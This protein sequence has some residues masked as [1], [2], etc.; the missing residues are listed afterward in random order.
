MADRMIPEGGEHLPVS[1]PRNLALGI[2]RIGLLPIRYPIVA[3]L[4]FLVLLALGA[5]GF[6][7]LKVDDSLSQLFRSDTPEYKIYQEVTHRFPASE[8]DVLVVIEGDKLM[9]RDSL[10]KLRDMAIDLQLIDGT[11]GLISLFSAREPPPSGGGVPPPL[12]PQ[13][14]PTGAEY[15]ALVHRVLSNEIIRGKLVS[16]DGKLALFVLALDPKAVDNG[17]LDKIVA[18]V[19]STVHD[20]LQ[21]AGLK[22]ELSGVPVMQLEIRNA[23]ERDRL[24][25][26]S[27]GFIAGC[28]IAV[29]FFRRISFMIIAAGPPLAAILLA[30]GTLGW[31]DFRLNMFLNVMTP[32]IMVISFSD[33]MQLTFAARDRLIA[34]DSKATAFR[35][36]LYIVGP[37]C[38][39][40]HATAGVSFIALMFSQ[41]DLIRAFGEAGLVAV[42][43]AMVAVLMLV[44]LLGMLL[45]RNESRFAD[46]VRGSD[47]GLDFLRRFC[48]WI[49]TQ[50]VSRPGLYT[51]TGLL[52][53]VGLSAVYM[54][55][56]PRYRL[57][58][59]LPDREQAV[60]AA[61]RL[62][63]KLT[64]ANPIDVLI[65]IPKGKSL[66]D[67]ETLGVIADVHALVEKQAGVGNVWSLQTLRN[68]LSE[69]LHVN[70]VA[71]LKSYV[72]ILPKYLT[73][74]FI[75]ANQDAVIVN[76]R[77][78]DIDASQLLPVIRSLD[79][80]LNG[81]RTKYPGYTIAVTGLSA[82]AARNS[83]TMIDRLSW[84]LTV[85]IAFVA[86]FI[87]LAFR[88]PIVMLVS[89]LPGIFPIV[90]AGT[91]LF[92]LGM[93]LQ[94]ASVIALT[95]SFGLGL[96]ATIHFLNR[97]QLEDTDEDDP[98][99]GVE[100]ATVLVGPPLILT[101]AVL[102]CGLAMTVFSSLPSLRLFGWLSA[103]AM[104]SA[105][106]AD[107]FILRP[108]A[109]YLSKVMR[110]VGG[111]HLSGPSRKELPKT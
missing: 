87:G 78:P 23:I 67:P 96:S 91:L 90:A 101:S 35:N 63:A 22:Q 43:V 60:Q 28:L 108:V 79:R 111:R 54:Q 46:E 34:G 20:D 3:A 59:Q 62:D 100:R 81:V 89:I 83:A 75:S 53:V 4:A 73:R 50:M 37:A 97:L 76:G 12:F 17:Q 7:R 106:V 93:G 16:D 26:N 36:A 21:G 27:L 57:A 82:I 44:P 88:S 6:E 29:M 1:G 107:L 95:V 55:L 2:E 18:S 84:G 9:A 80:Q 47:T 86:A 71:T 41:S 64:G 77:V 98:G 30:L 65:E 92:V 15:D 110:R 45:V 5:V 85:E 42:A 24:I 103:F 56:Q 72:D 25:Y 61:H 94:F 105:L 48:S 32:L 51:L 70:D 10:E 68:W 69:K 13:N 40:T 109:M 99:V 49:A 58:D 39:L 52:V 19:R 66:Y 104:I 33:S 8:Y 31:L 38:V 14:L 11:R 74:R 102:A